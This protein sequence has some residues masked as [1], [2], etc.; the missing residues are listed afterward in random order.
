MIG[1]YKIL[2][3]G[4]VTE[5][6]DTDYIPLEFDNIIEFRP[7]YPEPPHTEGDHEMIETYPGILRDLLKRERRRCTT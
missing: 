4:V 3:K 7:D 2:D 1:K 5:Y 6:A